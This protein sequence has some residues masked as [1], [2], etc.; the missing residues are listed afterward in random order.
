MFAG[1]FELVVW[2]QERALGGHRRAFSEG[3]GGASGGIGGHRGAL[4]RFQAK[5][6][7]T[8][9][10]SCD[11][12]KIIVFTKQNGELLDFVAPLV[13]TAACHKKNKKFTTG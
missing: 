1:N 8:K 6:L 10:R 7:Q 5:H 9:R 4:G 2:L 11:V 13:A 12:C 3:I